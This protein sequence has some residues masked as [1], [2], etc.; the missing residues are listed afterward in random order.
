MTTPEEQKQAETEAE[1]YHSRRFYYD[2]KEIP[3]VPAEMA[4]EAVQKHL[5]AFLPELAN[6]THTEKVADGVLVVTFHKQVTSKGNE[7]ILFM[8]LVAALPA[9]D[10]P[11]VALFQKLGT[12]PFTV[13]TLAG[14]AAEIQA[15]AAYI[16]AQLGA[17]RE[18][19]GAC[20]ALSPVSAAVIPVGF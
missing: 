16:Q 9:I 1:P 17:S 19:V 12:G 11:A 2:G 18:I 14:Q 10:H 20:G 5:A 7:H 8:N 6:A 13:E 4:I 15:A 3:H